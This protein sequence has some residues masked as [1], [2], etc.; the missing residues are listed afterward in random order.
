MRTG[1]A[2]LLVTVTL[3]GASCT[4]K[5]ANEPPAPGCVTG[6][7]AL[8]HKPL[9]VLYEV[10]PWLMV[11]GSD[12]PRVTI[13]EDGL[14][15]V[16]RPREKA[17][18]D[19]LSTHLTPREVADLSARLQATGVGAVAPYTD[20]CKCSDAS[21]T[22]ILVRSGATWRGTSMYGMQPDGTAV[23]FDPANAPPVP[24]AFVDAYRLLADYDP[25]RAAPWSPETIE[26]ML[27]DFSYSTMTP[28][29][30]PSDVPAPPAAAVAPDGILPGVF[31]YSVPGI[32]EAK[33][34]ALQRSLDPHQAVGIRGRKWTL[35]VKITLPEE[36]YIQ[37]VLRCAR[38]PDACS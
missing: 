11:I 37:E 15:I 27:G 3:A 10:N 30:W 31:L 12:V 20:L 24:R 5:K 8:V 29:P 33:L 1:A 9:I 36:A 18:P 34:R 38:D 19:R 7:D 35:G 23:T 16:L 14:V 26:V 28:A 6:L 32:H 25:P 4:K 21:T 22:T 2:L 13:Y 17:P